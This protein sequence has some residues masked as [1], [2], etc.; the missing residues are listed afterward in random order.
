MAFR[1]F[2]NGITLDFG[3]TFFSRDVT[4]RA[5]LY[6]LHILTVIGKKSNAGMRLD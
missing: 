6:F 2:T 4:F 1:V 3:L 5:L